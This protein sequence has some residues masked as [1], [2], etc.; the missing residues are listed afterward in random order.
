[1]PSGALGAD[2]PY[3]MRGQE[4]RPTAA[5]VGS[6]VA[7]FCPSR[8]MNRLRKAP[9]TKT[10]L[11][12]GRGGPRLGNES[13]L[14]RDHS[15]GNRGKRERPCCSSLRGGRAR[16]P[17]EKPP[18]ARPPGSEQEEEN[19]SRS[20]ERRGATVPQPRTPERGGL[21]KDLGV[22]RMEATWLIL[23]VVICLSQRLS[24]AC[25]SINYLIL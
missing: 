3:A 9:P 13:R 10:R 16:T 2:Q 18:P 15:N 21:G 24:H 25:L 5:P 22:L 23:P 6:S 12:E 20:Q 14:R 1:M 17:Q 7:G 11:R 8:T 4:I 19:I